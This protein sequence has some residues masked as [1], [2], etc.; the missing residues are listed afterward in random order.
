MILK[1]KILREGAKE[2]LIATKGAAGADLYAVS[3]TIDYK[4]G[5]VK[6]KT[7]LAVEVPK[8]YVGLLFSRSSICKK[9]LI[10]SNCVGVIDSDYRG[11]VSVVYRMTG[12]KGITR[13]VASKL[14]WFLFKGS[15][16]EF[17]EVGER[18]GQLVI[19]PIAQVSKIRL[20]DKLS[21]TE[22]GTGGYG[23]TGK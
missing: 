22:R 3:R 23:S 7:G 5:L 19:V 20:V 12:W 11:D 14:F 2:P 17:Y 6:Y 18:V 9:G 13:Y 4:T 8:G 1:A 16:D 21:V 10:Q 15:K